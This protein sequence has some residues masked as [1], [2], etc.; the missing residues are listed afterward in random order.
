MTAYRPD[1]VVMDLRMKRM[2]GIEATRLLRRRSD[3]PPVLVLTTFGDDE[4]LSG[5]LRSGAAG[6]PA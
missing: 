6:N 4:M 3:A 2:H 5:A 1:V